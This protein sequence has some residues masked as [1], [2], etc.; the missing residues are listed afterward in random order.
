MIWDECHR[1]GID[2][3]IDWELCPFVS[4]RTN[5][6]TYGSSLNQLWKASVEVSQCRP[7]KQGSAPMVPRR[8]W[9]CP[10]LKRI[11][12]WTAWGTASSFQY[13]F[14]LFLIVSVDLDFSAT[15]MPRVELLRFSH[16]FEVDTMLAD[17]PLDA[18]SFVSSLPSIPARDC[19]SFHGA[20]GERPCHDTL[21]QYIFA[22]FCHQ[23]IYNII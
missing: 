16:N 19:I 7:R 8:Q 5:V 23:D 22:L 13:V 2:W 15:F 18:G 20:C 1:M 12:G 9:Q 10:L 14:W 17:L 11:L 4:D 3:G 21:I 6:K